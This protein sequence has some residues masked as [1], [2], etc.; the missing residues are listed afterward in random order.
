M[1]WKSLRPKAR[2]I[3]LATLFYFARQA[4]WTPDATLLHPVHEYH[5][6]DE[7]LLAEER[8][9][10][11]AA[12]NKAW[13]LLKDSEYKKHPYLESKGFP[14][15]E[16]LVNGDLL[17]VPISSAEKTVMSVQTI[18][19]DGEK[20]FL[21]GGKVSGGRFKMGTSSK[22]RTWYVEGFATAL[23]L[24]LA[25]KDLN[26]NENI[27]VCFSAAGLRLAAKHPYGVIIPDND[28]WRCRDRDCYAE[29]EGTWPQTE[30]VMCGTKSPIPP[31][32]EKYAREADKKFWIP[33]G[34]GT[35]LNDYHQKYGLEAVIQAMRE[36]FLQ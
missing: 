20:K 33:T 14:D 16:W 21:F 19:P 34:I 25:L 35:D 13:A 3:T 30:C 11:K 28:P 32:S 22:K 9:I 17:L 5:Y 8:R 2:E 15:H 27:V 36:N 6:D 31:P 24:Q 29:W 1:V 7:A 10:Q 12:E 4:G 18:T 26:I 23:S